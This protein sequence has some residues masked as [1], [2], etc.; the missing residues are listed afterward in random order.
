MDLHGFF[1]DTENIN[2]PSF[3]F[4]LKKRTTTFSSLKKHNHSAYLS[5][6]SQKAV[7]QEPEMRNEAWWLSGQASASAVTASQYEF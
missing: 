3:F 4:F 7:K 6:S 5:V 1:F 2:F